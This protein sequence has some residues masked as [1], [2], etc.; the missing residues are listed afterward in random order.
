MQDDQRLRTDEDLIKQ[1]LAGDEAAFTML[2][3]RHQG[4]V[5]RFALHMSGSASVAEDTVQDAFMIFMREARTY[6]AEKGRVGAFLYGI[7]RNC[8]LRRLAKDKFFVAIE[9]SAAG[10]LEDQGL[11]SGREV[12][13]ADDPLSC[14]TRNEAIASVRLAVLALP[15]RYREVVVLCDLQEMSY[16]D[17]AAALGCAIGTVRSRLHR[18]R[19]LLWEKLRSTYEVDKDRCRVDA[20]RCLI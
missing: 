20:A 17:A 4:P 9:E 18:A 10:V 7:A 19:K 16:V 15:A 5:F 3:R 13:I 2:Y 8:V 12:V 14:A 6:D 11:A 1:M